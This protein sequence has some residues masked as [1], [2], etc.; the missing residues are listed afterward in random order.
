MTTP[1]F[2]TLKAGDKV[3]RH[4]GIHGDESLARVTLIANGR[5]YAEHYNAHFRRWIPGIYTSKTGRASGGYGIGVYLEPGTPERIAQLEAD[6][7]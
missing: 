5:I 3:I 2:S 6:S 7:R 1:D 4:H